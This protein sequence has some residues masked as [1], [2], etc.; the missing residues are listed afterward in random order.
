MHHKNCSLIA[1][2]GKRPNK[3]TTVRFASD[4]YVCWLGW[5]GVREPCAG[6]AAGDDAFPALPRD[7]PHTQGPTA[8]PSGGACERGF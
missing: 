5:L 8:C 6:T 2:T 7:C 4:F 3:N 1:I